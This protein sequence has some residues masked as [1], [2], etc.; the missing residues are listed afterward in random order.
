MKKLFFLTEGGP[1]VGLGHIARCLAIAETAR[2]DFDIEFILTEKSRACRDMIGEKNFLITFIPELKDALSIDLND[3]I[4]VLDSYSSEGE[5]EGRISQQGA[6]LLCLDDHASGPREAEAIINPAGGVSYGLYCAE[7]PMLVFTGPKYAPLRTEFL[8]AAGS[9][10]SGDFGKDRKGILICFGGADPNNDLFLYA[11]KCRNLL[12]NEK[13]TLVSSGIHSFHKEIPGF[14]SS[15]PDMFHK[16]N[17]DAAQLANELSSHRLAITSSS[18]IANEACSIRIPLI[19]VLTASNQ[20]NLF[21]FLAGNGLAC[22]LEHVDDLE[23]ALKKTGNREQVKTQQAQQQL[24]FDGRSGERI[25]EILNCLTFPFYMRQ[26]ADRDS[27]ILLSWANDP[28][29]RLNSYYSEM[30]TKDV[31]EKWYR[32]KLS[33]PGSRIWLAEDNESIG[34]VRIDKEEDGYTMSINLAPEQRGKGLAEKVLRMASLHFFSEFPD[35]NIYAWIKKDNILSQKAFSAAGFIFVK[36]E[37]KH[38]VPSVQ[39]LSEC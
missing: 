8:D 32:K 14:V 13:I 20:E 6:K 35:E 27:G 34:M 9:N 30:I 29:T 36:E 10:S 15:Q 5:L 1:G 38:D 19:A 23:E 4:V 3:S 24:F 22:C 28:E 39:M 37:M 18:T 26:A 7:S 21:L 17:L 12:P 16:L 31:H 33:D 2:Q 25:R 11:R